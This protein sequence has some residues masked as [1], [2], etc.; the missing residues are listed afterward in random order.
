MSCTSRIQTDW[1]RWIDDFYWSSQVPGNLPSSL[2]LHGKT[3]FI[4]PWQVFPS[5]VYPV[6]QVQIYDP[7]VLEQL[8]L[9]SHTGEE[10]LHSSMSRTA[11]ILIDEKII[12]GHLLRP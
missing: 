2:L 1:I 8:A 4:I 7:R 10:A 6:L 5:P 12:G 9:M 11:N 3:T